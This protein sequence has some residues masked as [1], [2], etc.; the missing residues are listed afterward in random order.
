MGMSTHVVG[1]APPDEKWKR[2]RSVW[3]AC[4]S[5]GVSA[6]HEV[7]EFFN[8]QYP[9]EQGIEVNLERHECCSK[10]NDETRDGFEI[11]LRKVPANVQYIRF[12][13]SY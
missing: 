13:N 3:E 1:F 2:M 4:E 6:P 9:D 8:G 10:H 5:A 11:D 12:Y 7:I